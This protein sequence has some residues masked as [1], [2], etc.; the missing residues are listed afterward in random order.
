MQALRCDQGAL[1]IA[2]NLVRESKCGWV[3]QSSK[4]S[5]R[6]FAI[7]IIR[8]SNQGGPLHEI[9]QGGYIFQ[10]LG[11]NF[12]GQCMRKSMQKIVKLNFV[13]Q[14]RVYTVDQK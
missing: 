12:E 13:A 1:I 7:L 14:H 6:F 10:N 3:F 2:Y 11:L 9:K 5:L 4:E 8:P